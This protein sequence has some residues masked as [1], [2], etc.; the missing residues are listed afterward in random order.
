LA[1]SKPFQSPIRWYLAVLFLGLVASAFV[2]SPYGKF[3]LQRIVEILLLVGVLA[4]SYRRQSAGALTASATTG[5]YGLGLVGFSLTALLAGWSG[6]IPWI[7]LAFTGLVWMQFGLLPLLR[8]AWE[9]Y[10]EDGIR[11]LALF[12]FCLVGLDVALWLV[13]H[14]NAVPVYTWAR[15]FNALGQLDFQ[16]PY[17]FLNPRWGNQ[18]SV[19]LLWTFVPLLDQLQRGVVQRFQ[20]FWWAICWLVPIV[21][22]LQ[23]VL[24]EGDGAFLASCLGGA[25]LALFAALSQGSQRQFWLRCLGLV[26][27]GVVV[28]SVVSF[29]LEAGSFFANL[30]QRNAQEVSKGVVTA[31]MGRADFRLL[32]WMLYGLASLQWPIWGVGIQVVPQGS[33]VCGP[34]SLPVELLY[35]TGLLGTAA[36]ALLTTGF[37][38][39]R[40]GELVRSQSMAGLLSPM[41]VALFAYQL[42]DDIWLKPASLALLLLVLAAVMRPQPTQVGPLQPWAL[43]F[44]VY[45]LLALLGLLMIVISV[46][47]PGGVGF[48][49]SPLV[50]LPGKDCLLFF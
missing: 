27:V 1:L 28:A 38:P 30:L 13:M 33:P 39:R 21:C 20:R 50:S 40:L 15:K 44:Q 8:P 45:R 48:G 36:A 34:H 5:W 41:L 46:V 23:I 6:P 16:A 37:W 3:Q 11:L 17:L 32:N 10:G 25:V 31:E 4:W 18:Y 43:S 26:V 24:T 29:G 9:R 22:W 19:L 35:W 47:R 42:I 12:G 49:P 2:G 7:S 14:A